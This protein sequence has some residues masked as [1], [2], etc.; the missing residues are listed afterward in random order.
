MVELNLIAKR[1]DGGAGAGVFTGSIPLKP[2]QHKEVGAYSSRQPVSVWDGATE[3]PALVTCLYPQHLDGSVKSLQVDVQL[4]LP[5]LTAKA[6]T[7]KVGTPGTAPPPTPTVVSRASLRAPRLLACSDA[8]H[9]CASRVALFPLVPFARMVEPYKTMLTTEFEICTILDGNKNPA[10]PSYA[11]VLEHLRVLGDVAATYPYQDANYNALAPMYYRYLMSGN[12]DH[13][14]EAHQMAAGYHDSYSWNPPLQGGGYINYGKGPIMKYGA[15]PPAGRTVGE[16]VD[17]DEYN[18]S[19]MNVT[20]VGNGEH[21]SGFHHNAWICYVL[22]G[23]NQPLG[24]MLSFSTRAFLAKADGTPFANYPWPNIGPKTEFHT[25]TGNGGWSGARFNMRLMRET[26]LV[27]LLVSL[28]FELTA[29]VYGP[30]KMPSP[31][32]PVNR[33][34]YLLYVKRKVFDSVA[35]WCTEFADGQPSSFLKGTW[36]FSPNFMGSYGSAPGTW[37]TFQAITVFNTLLLAFHHFGRDER[38]KDGMLGLA[39]FLLTQV[40]GPFTPTGGKGRQLYKMPYMIWD[41]AKIDSDF[42]TINMNYWTP[43]IVAPAFAWAARATPDPAEAAKFK[44]V[45]EACA[46]IYAMMYGELGGVG[47]ALKQLG[48][49]HHMA[50]TAAAFASGVAWDGWDLPVVVPPPPPTLETLDQRVGVLETRVATLEA[51]LP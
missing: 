4:S 42:G 40:R 24:V 39:R 50:A 34:K 11:K 36:G 17:L 43:C 41:P 21:Q 35:L 2:G 19:P 33:E 44:A 48:E 38:F 10:Y 51:K 9:L 47:C 18:V 30:Y 3:V 13:L 6:L 28:P 45:A 23:W 46:S 29:S 37:P 16:E 26:E 14:R 22:S 20:P 8:E 15:N 12:I 32:D 49:H 5:N 25:P 1:Y 7:L 31:R 27:G